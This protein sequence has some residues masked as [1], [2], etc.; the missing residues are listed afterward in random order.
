MLNST[1]YILPSGQSLIGPDLPTELF[2]HAI[3]NVNSTHSL[4][5][6]GWTS[7]SNAIDKT[8]Y[9]DQVTKTF[10]DGPKLKFGRRYHTSGVIYDSITNEKIIVVVGGKNSDHYYLESTEILKNEKWEKGTWYLN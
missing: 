4:L 3:T 9:F 7:K 5:I 1:E 10:T 6:G 2:G 8:W